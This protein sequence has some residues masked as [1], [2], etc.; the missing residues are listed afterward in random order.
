[1]VTAPAGLTGPVPASGVLVEDD[2][3]PQADNAVA[4]IAKQ[5]NL[6]IPLM[7][8]PDACR[9]PQ[10][11]TVLHARRAR[12]A[13]RHDHTANMGLNGAERTVYSATLAAARGARG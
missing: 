4:R 9:R 5:L 11:P 1:M 2:F 12:A 13:E 10:R 6:P 7:S 3:P 8:P